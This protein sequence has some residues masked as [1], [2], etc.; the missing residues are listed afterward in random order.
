[1]TPNAGFWMIFLGYS[2]F[3]K[4]T[5]TRGSNST[6]C[7]HVKFFSQTLLETEGTFIFK[8]KLHVLVFQCRMLSIFRR[9]K[10][11]QDGVQRYVPGHFQLFESRTFSERSF[12]SL[13]FGPI[14]VESSSLASLNNKKHYYSM[15]QG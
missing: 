3:S 1:M 10:I 4:G 7:M 2:T 9:R 6:K 15:Q 8:L 12:D 14:N 11:T 5:L 13:V